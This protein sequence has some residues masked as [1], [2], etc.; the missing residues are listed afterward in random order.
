MRN[1]LSFF[2]VIALGA[3]MVSGCAGPEAK[4]GRGMVNA[5]EI[6]RMGE[7]RRSIEQT[8]V[9][10]SPDT[11]YSFG[12]VRGFDRTMARTGLGV[13][14]ILTFPFPPYHP[15]FTRYISPEPVYPDNYKPG[16]AADPLFDTHTYIGFSGGDVA[17]FVPGSRFKVYDSN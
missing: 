15:L 10:D 7:L 9:F 4:L 1:A 2:S 3:M 12:L 5:G 6:V 16:L 11:G 17:P 13:Y 14:D 8:A